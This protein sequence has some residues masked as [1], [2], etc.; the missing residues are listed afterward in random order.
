[1]QEQIKI[2]F[3][4]TPE[5]A[6]PSLEA[7]VTH[8]YN[9]VAVVTAADAPAGRGLKLRHS[10]VKDCALKHGLKVLQPEKL[11]SPDFLNEVQSLNADLQIVVAFRMMP[12]ELWSMPHMGTF[13]LHSSLLPQYRGA[14]PINRAIMNGEKETGVTTF[15]LQ[16]EIDTGKIIFQEKVCIGA[17]ETATM[18]HDRLKQIGAQLVIKTVQTIIDEKVQAIEQSQLMQGELKL[19]PKIFKD[20]CRIDWKASVN[21]IHNL[22]RGLSRYPT[23]FTMLHATDSY[24]QMVKIYSAIAEHASHNLSAGSIVTDYRTYLKVATAE[25]FIIVTELQLAGKKSMRTDEFLRGFKM[26][27]QF[28]F[29]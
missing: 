17:E 22:I 25:G 13:N 9:V 27:E 5:F 4:G 21:V 29:K 6:V 20:D 19:A 2:I 1:M 12:F 26:N 14:A 8:G 7:L 15:F 10:A 11:K 23:A 18:L 28:Y 3:Y 16:Q 24:E